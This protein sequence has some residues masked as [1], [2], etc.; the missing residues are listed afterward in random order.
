ML[1]S[2]SAGRADCA[3]ADLYGAASVWTM[4]APNL[5]FVGAEMLTEDQK[6]SCYPIARPG[7]CRRPGWKCN[8]AAVST[9]PVWTLH[10]M[11]SPSVPSAFSVMTVA[12]PAPRGTSPSAAPELLELFGVHGNH[13]A[14]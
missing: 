6:N 5:G 14:L 10:V 9:L 13:T 1:L 12:P 3:D 2:T 8:P 4:A 11:P 7:A